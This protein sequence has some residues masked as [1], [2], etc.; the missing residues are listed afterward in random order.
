MHKRPGTAR[1][2]VLS[3]RTGP[4]YGRVE[5]VVVLVDVVVVVLVDV[6]VVDDVVVVGGSLVV[7]GG[8][9]VVVV[10]GGSV[11]GATGAT[12]GREGSVALIT[13]VVGEVVV[14]S[15]IGAVEDVVILAGTAACAIEG[16]T[17]ADGMPR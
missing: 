12:A 13:A 3:G 4:A 9:V 6:V 15:A 11:V 8:T 5:V 7:V 16:G 10:A 14:E 1:A 17:S 2:F